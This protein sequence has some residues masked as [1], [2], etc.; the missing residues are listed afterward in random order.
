MYGV[1]MLSGT[2]STG[3]L[4]AQELPDLFPKN[5]YPQGY[6]AWPVDASVGIVANFGE[7]RPNHYHMG[8]DCRTDQH[9][10]VPVLA[11][12]EGYI[13]KVKIEPSGFGRCL[14][15]NH[16]NGHTTLYA[17][18][19]DFYPELESWVKEQQY[20]LESWAVF[21]DVPPGLFKVQK[22]QFIAYSGN[23]GGSQGPHLHFEVRDTKTDKVLNPLRMGFPIEDD[24]APDII[25]LAWYDRSKSTYEQSPR[26][27]PIRKRNGVYEATLPVVQLPARLVSFAIS[28]FDRTTGS[29][30]QNGIFEATI[31]DNG[32]PQAGFRLD[33]IGYDETRYLN[34]HIDFKLKGSGGPFLQHLSRL[35][36]YPPGV[37]RGNKKDGVIELTD[38]TTHHL[39]IVVKDTEGNRSV[40]Q[41]NIKTSS[42]GFP[43]SDK[44][45]TGRNSLL[46]R[47]GYV[48]VFENQEL[49]FYLP[50]THIYDSFY[51]HLNE[52]KGSKGNKAFQLTSGYIPIHS[53][54][55]IRIMNSSTA[56][57]NRMVLRRWWGGKDDYDKPV[58][59]GNWYEGRFKALGNVELIADTQP[60]VISLPGFREGMN[61]AQLKRLIVVVG[62][63][64][65][66][67]RN[68]RAE[69]DGKWLRFS[70]DKG[71]SFIYYFDEKCP[72]GD[73]ELKISVEDL[74]GNRTEKTVHFSR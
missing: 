14:Y 13:A 4:H 73:H 41:L 59:R 67:R 38:T 61:A 42:T 35:P 40:I 6:Y 25:R 21:L 10:N 19:N 66:E 11:A 22:G 60:P 70:N 29:G 34:A 55:P 53:Y 7:L 37:Y 28:A 31:Y 24:V 52:I 33:S 47:P 2:G 69:L 39:E 54:F 46:F 5:Q 27:I 48:N 58:R 43:I 44:E 71:R 30:N 26:Y 32:E 15:I 45:P 57:P 68:F 62:E 65:D 1:L 49:F 74:A 20:R 51:F 12:A 56:Y 9:E 8:L 64:T 18:L 3:R 36:G 72:P 50:E 17:H 23:T 16:P 63:E